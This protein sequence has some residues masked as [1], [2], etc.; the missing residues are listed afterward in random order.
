MK[1]KFLLAF[2]LNSYLPHFSCKESPDNIYNPH[3][4]STVELCYNYRRQCLQHFWNVQCSVSD[5]LH[6]FMIPYDNYQYNFACIGLWNVFTSYQNW[7]SPQNLSSDWLLSHVLCTH[8]HALNIINVSRIHTCKHNHQ[9]TFIF[10]TFSK[11][12]ICP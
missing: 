1:S 12:F 4:V 10:Q 11:Y 8:A 5:I 6:V 9:V 7:T 2:F 3:F